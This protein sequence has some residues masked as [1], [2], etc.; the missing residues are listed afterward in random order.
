MAPPVE[1]NYTPRAM[2]SRW[3]REIT[4]SNTKL[5]PVLLL[6]MVGGCATQP[7]TDRV[8]SNAARSDVQCHQEQATGSMFGKTVCTTQPQRDAPVEL[9]QALPSKTN[10][11]RPSGC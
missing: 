4:M 10:A 5:W 6:I 2:E 1:T 8:A 3:T 9:Q 11:C 7:K